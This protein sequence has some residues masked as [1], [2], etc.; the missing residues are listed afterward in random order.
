M[1]KPSIYYCFLTILR[2]NMYLFNLG[3]KCRILISYKAFK[4]S[5][6]QVYSSILLQ[7]SS[8]VSKQSTGS[9]NKL[10]FI[11]KD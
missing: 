11:K 4:I 7:C 9:K 6:A 3:E 10:Y 8:P 1:N 5:Y 2:E